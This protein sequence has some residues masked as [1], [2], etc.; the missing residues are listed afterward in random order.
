MLRLRVQT[1]LGL[2]LSDRAEAPDD[3]NAAVA[4][5]DDEASVAGERDAGVPVAGMRASFRVREE[6]TGE[7]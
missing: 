3:S 1:L 2:L 4:L 5:V 6:D 7:R